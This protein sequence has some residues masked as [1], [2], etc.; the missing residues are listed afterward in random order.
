MKTKLRLLPTVL[1]CV[2]ALVL[3]SA[4]SIVVVNL[5]TNRSVISEFASRAIVRSL[6]GLQLMLQAHLDAARHQAEFVADGIRSGDL[7]FNEREKLAEF[8]A[9]SLAAAPQISG[10]LVAGAD[11]HAVAVSRSPSGQAERRWLSLE[12]DP[13]VEQLAAET[14]SRKATYWGPP[15]YR[16]QRKTTLLNLRVPIWRGNDY[17]GFVAVG[18]STQALSQ[19]ALELSEPPR[20]TVFVLLG[21]DKVLAHMFLALRPQGLSVDKPLLGI[22][23]VVDPVIGRLAD[24]TPLQFVSFR[25]P[26][27]V[28]ARELDSSGT[29]Y[30][31]FEKTVSGY[32]RVPL[33]IGYYS[34]ATALN[35]PIRAMYR[36]ILIGLC[37]L[38]IA[39]IASVVMSRMITRAV[40]DTSDSAAAIAS[41]DFDDVAPLRPSLIKE[42]DDLS[43]S[44]NAMLVGLKSFGRY[45]PRALVNRLIREK[46]VGAG[47]EERDLTVMFTDIAGF[48][49]TCEGL[50]PAE[51]AAFINHH[52]ALVC[53]CIDSEGGTID[54]YIGD[55]VMA[56]WG[57]PDSI[58]D[59]PIRACR[60]AVAIQSA[61]AADNEKRAAAGLPRVR[62]RIGI[63]SGPLIVG[64]IGAPNRINYTVVGDVVNA[65]QRLEGL[66]KEIDPDAES[67]V[68]VSRSTKDALD[69][70]FELAKAGRFKMKGK[71]HELGVYRIVSRVVT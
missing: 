42:V 27:D 56:F 32:G 4:G 11:G 58:D 6:D 26:K 8:A 38:A 15:V 53:E 49:A 34:A 50:S 68:L 33:V 45:V 25:L 44:F 2:G 43:N 55:A 40:R 60:A 48:T 16:E 63:H 41:L 19:L 18:I 57:A 17:L 31:V 29:R 7:S 67:I 61:L 51:V 13:Q 71:Q 20:S 22:D 35:A 52:I 9:G 54:K 12:G 10:M 59:A 70:S 5:L 14:R 23:E 47:T 24:A 1:I 3:L 28:D 30:L 37:V 69:D 46:R 65:A 64:D 21:P 39:L 62:M 66:G 36:A